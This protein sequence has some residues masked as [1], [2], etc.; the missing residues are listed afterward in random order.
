MVLETGSWKGVRDLRPKQTLLLLLRHF[1]DFNLVEGS[2][3]KPNV[4]SRSFRWST[5]VGRV[6]FCPG[7]HLEPVLIYLPKVYSIDTWNPSSYSPS[8]IPLS[9]EVAHLQPG[10]PRFLFKR[11]SYNFVFL[12]AVSAHVMVL[13]LHIDYCRNLVA[14]DVDRV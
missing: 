8:S 7:L 1:R 5:L 9:S 4:R 10:R 2:A 11:Q 13:L 12:L 6:S 14:Q 3:W